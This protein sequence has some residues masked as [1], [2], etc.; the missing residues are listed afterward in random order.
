MRPAPTK[1]ELGN[2]VANKS[3]NKEE[4]KNRLAEYENIIR[5]ISNTI[6]NINYMNDNNDDTKDITNYCQIFTN[7][8]SER[9]FIANTI[10]RRA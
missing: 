8:I 1:I 5:L 2:R 7:I 4:V 10:D 3:S 9:C 6:N